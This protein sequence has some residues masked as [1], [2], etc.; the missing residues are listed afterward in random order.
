MRIAAIL[1]ASL[2]IGCASTP[3]PS[4]GPTSTAPP[5]PAAPVEPAATAEPA[6]PSTAAAPAGP[7]A[8]PALDLS[9]PEKARATI[10]DVLQKGDREAFKRCVTARILDRQ[11]DNFDAWYGVWKSAADKTPEKFQKVTVTQEEGVYKLDEN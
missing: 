8:A 2:F 6:A 9:T 1:L 5:E 4:A 3:E 11:K 10:V 7:D